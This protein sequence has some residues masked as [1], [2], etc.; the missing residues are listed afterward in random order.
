M[1]QIVRT[2]STTVRHITVTTE[3]VLM[4]LTHSRAV[5]LQVS[6]E[7]FVTLT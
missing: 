2:I 4:V 1:A 5:V 6:L 3:L 7:N